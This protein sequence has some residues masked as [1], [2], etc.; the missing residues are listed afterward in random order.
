MVRNNAYYIQ[1]IKPREN[2]SGWLL[3]TRNDIIRVNKEEIF[4]NKIIL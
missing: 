4:K 2:D 3:D 1:L